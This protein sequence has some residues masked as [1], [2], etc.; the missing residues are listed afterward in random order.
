[1][2]LNMTLVIMARVATFSTLAILQ[3]DESLSSPPLSLTL[4]D[5]EPL[6]DV[7]SDDE[8]VSSSATLLA[9][10]GGGSYYM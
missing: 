5:G 1:M 2:I 4:S 7:E 10:F 8:T 3:L 9:R 6:L